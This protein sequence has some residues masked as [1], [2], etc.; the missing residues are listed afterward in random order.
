[1]VL[2]ARNG[3]AES[4]LASS[5]VRVVLP[6]LPPEPQADAYTVDED[7]S[8]LGVVALGVNVAEWVEDFQ[9]DP[10]TGTRRYTRTEIRGASFALG[11]REAARRA[12]VWDR[13]LVDPRSA[14]PYTGVR[15][16]KV[17]RAPPR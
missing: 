9:D 3:G 15:L 1:M 14:Y 7:T 8:P 2:R 12:R 11:E 16:V 17:H 10:E 4:S 13:T 6:P 5:F